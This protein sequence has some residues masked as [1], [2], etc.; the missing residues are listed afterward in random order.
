[1]N[2]LRR[3]NEIDTF[4]IILTTIAGG[5]MILLIWVMVWS[6]IATSS[7]S[8]LHKYVEEGKIDTQLLREYMKNNE[9]TEYEYSH[10]VENINKQKEF[11]KRRKKE[12][13]IRRWGRRELSR[14]ESTFFL[15]NS[16][17]CPTAIFFSR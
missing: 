2:I 6:E 15:L 8:D 10:L 4:I 3:I 9:I 13:L 12:E 1:V 17:A 5:F 7:Y 16:F 11:E 14:M